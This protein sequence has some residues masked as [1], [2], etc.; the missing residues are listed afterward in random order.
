MHMSKALE[1]AYLAA[2]RLVNVSDLAR[3]TGRAFRTLASYRAGERRVTPEAAR[4]LVT[5]LRSRADHFTR[6]ADKLDAALAREEEDR[7]G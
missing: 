1:R 7:H 2:L 5:Y 3:A 6:A 4:E